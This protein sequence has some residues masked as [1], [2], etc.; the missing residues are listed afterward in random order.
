MKGRTMKI[1]G[2]KSG[3]ITETFPMQRGKDS[4]LTW[5]ITALPMGFVER[6]RDDIPGPIPKATGVMRKG[7][8]VV[9]DEEG[10]P[11]F[12]TDKDT[13]EFQQR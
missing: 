6:I 3:L 12:L 4:V 10:K 8:K 7:G 11:V 2:A 5:Q 13:P 1:T 9:R